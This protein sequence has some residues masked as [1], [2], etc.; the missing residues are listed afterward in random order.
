MKCERR[1]DADAT[2]AVLDRLVAVRGPAP[3]RIRCDN[4]PGA[5]R[6]RAARLVPLLQGRQRV[7][8]AR[9]AVA[10][11]ICRVVRLQGAR[12]AL[13]VELFSYLAEAQ[14]MVED[15]REDYNH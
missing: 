11:P 13:S 15:W 10:E 8:R 6:E 12:R 1:I 7:H 4:G 2:V 14:V 9:L 3:E 5:D